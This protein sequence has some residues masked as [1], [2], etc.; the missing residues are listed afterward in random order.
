M[1]PELSTYYSIR[2]EITVANDILFK[3]E[4][5]ICP[6]IIWED[7]RERFHEG[8]LGQE[9]CKAGA[10]QVVFWPGINAEVTEMVL[11]CA[12]CQEHHSL[13]ENEILMFQTIHR[14]KFQT[15]HRK[16]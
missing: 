2:S 3:G 4:R 14:K 11:K 10:R 5:I 1:P 8:H 15:I 7:M 12:T 16:K 6:M 13:Q 9:K